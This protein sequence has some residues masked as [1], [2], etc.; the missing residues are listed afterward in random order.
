MTIPAT[1][2]PKSHG[3]VSVVVPA[4]NAAATIEACVRALANQ[5]TTLRYEILVVDDGSD[6]ATGTLASAVGARVIR[7]TRGRPAAARNVGIAAA[8]GKIICFT[9]ADCEPV[10]NWL[11]QIVEPLCRDPEIDAAKG[12]Y[13]TRQRALV[14]RFVQLEYE[15]K[16]DLMAS[17]ETIDF[18]DTYSAAYRATTLRTSGGFD[19]RFIYLEDQELS[20]RLAAVGHRMVFQPSAVV[21]HT[22]VDS[23]WA[24]VRKKFTI[25]YWKAQVV[26]RFPQRGVRDSHTPQVM[27]LQIAISAAL[28]LALVVLGVTAVAE[29]RV[30][31]VAILAASLAVAFL[32]TTLP[33]CAKAWPKDRAVAVL[34]PALL[35]A[36]ALG[37]GFGT[38]WGILAPPTSLQQ[39]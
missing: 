3:L 12:S 17:A 31:G 21:Y 25:G 35:L 27:K 14:S 7:T 34:A 24:Y 36:R 28:L 22:H 33:F 1:D 18:V 15:D 4:Y 32:L 37:L 39:D 19:P 9:D 38:L 11:E 13:A 8:S 26:R 23:L 5:V 2:E 10:A 29:W 6:D 20:F 16:Y 30:L